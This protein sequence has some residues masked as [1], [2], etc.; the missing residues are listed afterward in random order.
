MI[1][2]AI[3]D[4]VQSMLHLSQADGVIVLACYGLNHVGLIW[5]EWMLYLSLECLISSI[6]GILGNY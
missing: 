3:E 2:T 5:F 6:A 1:E 4:Y